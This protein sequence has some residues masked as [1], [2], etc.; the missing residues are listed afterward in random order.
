MIRDDDISINFD[1]PHTPQTFETAQVIL[2]KNDDK[3]TRN[4]GQFNSNHEEN[5]IESAH[6]QHFSPKTIDKILFHRKSFLEER[7][8]SNRKRMERISS[9]LNNLK[10]LPPINSM[11]KLDN[12]NNAATQESY[13]SKQNIYKYY[14]RLK[15]DNQQTFQIAET[16]HNEILSLLA[17]EDE[18]DI[19]RIKRTVLHIQSKN[20]ND[21]A[22]EIPSHDIMMQ[23]I[24][25]NKVS[26]QE[27]YKSSMNSIK[28]QEEHHV[29]GASTIQSWQRRNRNKKMIKPQMLAKEKGNSKAIT[30]KSISNGKLKTFTSA[31]ESIKRDKESKTRAQNSKIRAAKQINSTKI[32]SELKKNGL[33]IL[34]SKSSTSNKIIHVN[35][36]NKTELKDIYNHQKLENGKPSFCFNPNNLSPSPQRTSQQNSPVL[37][38]IRTNTNRDSL[39]DRELEIETIAPQTY[40]KSTT[41]TCSFFNIESSSHDQSNLKCTVHANSKNN[42]YSVPF[43]SSYMERSV[44]KTEVESKFSRNALERICSIGY[45]NSLYKQTNFKDNLSGERVRL[46]FFGVLVELK[47][48][49]KK[50]WITDCTEQLIQLI[51]HHKNEKQ[52]CLTSKILVEAI[53]VTFESLY[54]NQETF[55]LDLQCAS[56]RLGDFLS[57]NGQIEINI[58]ELKEYFEDVISSSKA[59]GPA[60][61]LGRSVDLVASKDQITGFDLASNFAHSNL[62]KNTR[63]YKEDDYVIKKNVEFQVFRKWLASFKPKLNTK[64]L[65]EFL[66]DISVVPNEV[67]SMDLF[68]LKCFHKPKRSVENLNQKIQSN[69]IYAGKLNKKRLESDIAVF[70]TFDQ[71]RNKYLKWLEFV[72]AVDA[73]TLM[74]TLGETCQLGQILLIHKNAFDSHDRIHYNELRKIVDR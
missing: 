33:L 27:V 62:I 24:A 57:R 72:K 17:R 65:E 40:S 19:D 31:I 64:D 13:W 4:D 55:F 25:K 2:H 56:L 67:V 23:D 44:S 43:E 37:Q 6:E 12:S 61:H 21:H 60:L 14:Q 29:S 73:T 48:H 38:L 18:L 58:I 46:C 34:N 32:D 28:K 66:I 52:A 68:L 3:I 11:L 1:D 42:R 63:L 35:N 59:R 49:G 70:E 30:D 20:E 16:R 54:K 10:S 69:Y 71:D 5:A 8:I 7:K 36:G 39:K 45:N 41:D 15:D 22:Q 51:A 50:P 53:K 47:R 9:I 26:N 74:L